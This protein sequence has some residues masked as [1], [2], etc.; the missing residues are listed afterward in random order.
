MPAR[1]GVLFFEIKKQYLRN[2]P[3]TAFGTKIAWLALCMFAGAIGLFAQENP[4]LD[5][6]Q[7]ALPKA[8]DDT[9]KVLLLCEMAWESK[10]NAPNEARSYLDSALRL[11][12]RLNYLKGLGTAYNYRGVVE[13]IHGNRTAAIENF[14]KALAIREQ[15]GDKTGVAKLYNNIGNVYENLGDQKSSLENYLKALA[16]YREVGD[17]ARVARASYN[18]GVLYENVGNFQAA[19]AY[20]LRYLSFAERQNDTTAIAYAHNVLGNIRMEKEDK[21]QA[22]AHY[23]I[24]L[25]LHQ[26][27]GNEWEQASVLNNIANALDEIGEDR[28]DEGKTDS[29]FQFFQDAIRFHRQSLHIRKRLDDPDGMG[30]SYN[31]LGLVYKNIG[32]FFKNNGRPDTA[33]VYWQK[34]LVYL[35]SS[36]QIRTKLTDQL[37]IME[38]YNGFGDVW[39]RL[40][41]P[42]K[43]LQYTQ[44]YLALAETLHNEKYLQNGYKDLARLYYLKGNYKLAYDWR[45]RYDEL[46][47]QRYNQDRLKEFESREVFFRD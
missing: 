21:M 9:S 46:K 41:N 40:G 31:N 28:M 4:Y 20:I 11:A 12:Q 24:A 7:K 17:S 44:K 18:L 23:K 13:D 25:R 5:S 8:T 38:V 39:R 10:I 42:D 30:E 26:S 32:T 15:L 35:D 47:E 43:A 45:V 16:L 2:H 34:A 1:P 14:Q 37:G 19:Q 22:L 27:Q 29:V 33:S 3:H 6:L 36:L